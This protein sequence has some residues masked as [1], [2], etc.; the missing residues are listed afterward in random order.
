MGKIRLTVQGGLRIL[1]RIRAIRGDIFRRR[2]QLGAVIWA[3][4]AR[5]S[6]FM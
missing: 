1:E 4:M 3:V 6:L 2:P 5:R